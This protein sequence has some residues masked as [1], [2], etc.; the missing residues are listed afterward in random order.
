MG[1]EAPKFV[2]YLTP[3]E[4]RA[5][6]S[7]VKEPNQFEFVIKVS[8]LIVRKCHLEVRNTVTCLNLISGVA[9]LHAHAV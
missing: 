6:K 4:A 9:M 5:R 2:Y 7:S 3:Y 1:I 8:I